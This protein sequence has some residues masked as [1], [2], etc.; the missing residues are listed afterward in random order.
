MIFEVAAVQ[1]QVVQIDVVEAA[2]APRLELGL[3][4]AADPRHRRLRHRR[5]LSKGLHQRRLHIAGRQPAHEPGDHQRLQRVGLGHVRAE[6]LRGEPLGG[7]A[8]L[9]P[10]Q[11]HRPRGGLDRGRAIPVAHPRMRVPTGRGPLIAVP[12]QECGHLGLNRALQQQLRAQLGDPLN[13]ARQILAA[14]EHLIDLRAQPLGGRYSLRHGRRLLPQTC[15][16]SREP[17]SDSF[18]TAPGTRPIYGTRPTSSTDRPDPWAPQGDQ[19][20]TEGA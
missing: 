1:K 3:D 20:T 2:G 14:G 12:P 16:S 17:T 7:A 10:G 11:R 15:W 5:L 8:Q 6:Q 4:L 9:G 19:G 13:R 18:Y